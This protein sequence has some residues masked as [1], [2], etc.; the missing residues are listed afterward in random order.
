MFKAVLYMKGA[1]S[2]INWQ[3]YMHFHTPSQDSSDTNSSHTDSYSGIC[4]PFLVNTLAGIT[5]HEQLDI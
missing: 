1:K 3:N 5:S 4:A 2:V